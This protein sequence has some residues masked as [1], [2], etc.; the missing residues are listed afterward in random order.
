MS[1]TPSAPDS[2]PPTFVPDG[3]VLPAGVPAPPE[4][5]PDAVPL[6]GGIDASVKNDA[7]CSPVG[8]TLWLKQ[9]QIRE[10]LLDLAAETLKLAMK[11]ELPHGGEH[12]KLRVDAAV[13]VLC[14]AY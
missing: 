5:A 3:A 2:A 9:R 12:S 11:G 14:R 10:E 8:D 1:E 4:V 6:T 13:A 7:E